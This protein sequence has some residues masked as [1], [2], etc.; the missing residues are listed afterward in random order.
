MIFFLRLPEG[1]TVDIV[2]CPVSEPQ[3]V[4]VVDI[5]E[6]RRRYQAIAPDGTRGPMYNNPL[7]PAHTAWF[8]REYGLWTEDEG[9]KTK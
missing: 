1:Y 7:Y 4:D 3:G 5:P 8:H 9:R 2:P 6:S